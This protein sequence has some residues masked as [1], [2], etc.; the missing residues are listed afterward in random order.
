MCKKKNVVYDEATHCN[1]VIVLVKLIGI[2]SVCRRVEPPYTFG[3]WGILRGREGI[4][5]AIRRIGTSF[6]GTAR[7]DAAEAEGELAGAGGAA[8]EGA[9][10]TTGMENVRSSRRQRGFEARRAGRPTAAGEGLVAS[11]SGCPC[12]A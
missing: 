10:I 6:V 7:D 8:E 4:P 5:I 3:R 11:A 2:V 9:L 12:P 1:T